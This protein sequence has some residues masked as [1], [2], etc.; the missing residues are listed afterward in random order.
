MAMEIARPIMK[1]N[2]GKELEFV[3]WIFEDSN[4]ALKSALEVRKA[5]LKHN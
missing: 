3:F 4:D 1:K 5:F 2:K